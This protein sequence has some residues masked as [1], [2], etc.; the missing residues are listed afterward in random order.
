MT[1]QIPDPRP[2]YAG[3]LTWVHGLLRA[4]RPAQLDAPTPCPD[5]DVRTLSGHLVGTVLRPALREGKVLY[6]RG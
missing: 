6:E 1:E 4:A 2:H 5:F 3:A